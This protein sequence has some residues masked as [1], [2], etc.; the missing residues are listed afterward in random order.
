MKTNIPNLNV[1]ELNQFYHNICFEIAKGVEEKR[2]KDELEELNR[3]LWQVHSTLIKKEKQR[4][5]EIRA[6]A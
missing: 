1:Y 2:A 5:L 3:L 4:K 6:L